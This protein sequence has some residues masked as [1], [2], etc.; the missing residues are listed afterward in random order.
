MNRKTAQKMNTTILH[1]VLLI[2]SLLFML[3]FIW[4]VSTSLKSD[5]Q[6]DDVTSLARILF[7]NPIQWSNYP[8]T[9]QY[10]DFFRYCFNT[11]YVTAMTI[12]GTALSCSIVA[13]S[14]ARM[15][16]V[17]RNTMFLLLLSTMMLPGQVTM[18]PVFL[19]FTHLGWVNSFKP[20]WVPSFFGA[21]FYI[22]LL[23]QFFLTIPMDLEDAAKIDGCSHFRT[24][25][26][27]MLPLIRPALATI[28][29]FQFMGAWND[30]LG[31]LI[32]I[33]DKNLMTLSI[34]LQ[35]F[36]SLHGGEW[37]KLM[38]ASTLMTL[39]VILL[40]FLAQKH[41]IQGITLTGL[42]G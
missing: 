3:P 23:R 42:K 6:I 9:I 8:K 34:A 19:I 26:Q 32:Y 14:F 25:Y 40:F 1:A 38:A 16:W 18:I 30:F 33:H 27:I 24:F 29:I 39:P 28:V 31:P 4:M 15:R 12:I 41:F 10:I 22:F 36:T 20:L 5:P 35:S 13:Y 11:C 37:S 2:G 21:A 7:P 17:G